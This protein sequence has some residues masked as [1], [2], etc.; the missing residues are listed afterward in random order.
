MKTPSHGFNE[1]RMSLYDIAGAITGSLFIGVTGYL[2][3]AALLWALC[4]ML[5]VPMAVLAGLLIFGMLGFTGLTIMLIIHALRLQRERDR[6]NP[7][8]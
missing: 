1:P 5:G 2:T 3:I 8:A 6:G 4:M 7:L